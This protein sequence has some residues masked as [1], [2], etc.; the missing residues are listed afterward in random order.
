MQNTVAT[1]LLITF[2]LFFIVLIPEGVMYGMQLVKAHDF[3]SDTIAVAE[4]NGGFKY[5]HENK[6]VNMIPN[7]EK[8]MEKGNMGDWKYKYTEGKVNYN[9][10]L[11]F[12]VRGEHQFTIFK[13][14]GVDGVKAP[15]WAHKDGI[16]QVYFR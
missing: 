7:I 1:A 11:S 12:S 14:F 9:E 15:I 13:I 2:S 6:N 3:V 10:P 16:G 4:K 8:S 5:T